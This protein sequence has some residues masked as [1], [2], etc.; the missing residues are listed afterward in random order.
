V[1]VLLSAVAE[2]FKVNELVVSVAISL[3]PNL[4]SIW[5]SVSALIVVSASA[6]RMSVSDA[7]LRSTFDAS[8]LGIAPPICVA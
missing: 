7:P 6:S 4:K 3:A 8:V 1:K 2:F 5:S